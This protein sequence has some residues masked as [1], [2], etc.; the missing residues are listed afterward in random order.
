MYNDNLRVSRRRWHG[1][2]YVA[3]IAKKVINRDAS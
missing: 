3:D 2:A 1:D